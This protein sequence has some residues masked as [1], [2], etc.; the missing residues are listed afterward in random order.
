MSLLAS[1]RDRI[2]AAR[3]NHTET[4]A[5]P[6]WAVAS[7]LARGETP[8]VRDDVLVAS[9]QS[10]GK[11]EDDLDADVQLLVQLAANESA[12]AT[13]GTARVACTRIT[14]EAA[15]LDAKATKLRDEATQ[16]QRK[17]EEARHHAT[18]AVSRAE[19][20]VNAAADVRAKLAAR[21]YVTAGDAIATHRSENQRVGRAHELEH[22]LAAA[23]R[24]LADVEKNDNGTTTTE[25]RVLWLARQ[26]ERVA[27]LEAELAQLRPTA[28]EKSTTAATEPALA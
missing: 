18:G 6:Y 26:R 21:G 28:T 8:K 13:L 5:S 9:M 20:A 15:D 7:A 2:R 17:A 22:Q 12:A 3:R 27:G 1:I 23:R 24:E 11:T 10:L 4:A 14:G 16:L 19:F 25:A